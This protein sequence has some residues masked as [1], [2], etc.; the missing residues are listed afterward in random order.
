MAQIN[1]T[2][3]ITDEACTEARSAIQQGW[4]LTPDSWEVSADTSGAASPQRTYASR[5]ARWA[6][7]Q[8][9]AISA[10]GTN[11]LM[12]TITIPPNA[13]S[14]VTQV[15]EIYFI[16]K[17]Y[18]GTKFLYAIAK[19]TSPIEYRPGVS[20]AYSFVFGLNNTTVA[21]LYTIDYTYPQDISDHNA[22]QSNDI[23]TMFLKKDGTRTATGVL[24]Y[25]AAKTF[26]TARDIVDKQYVDTADSA[27]LKVDGSRQPTGILRYNSDKTFSN[28]LDIVDKKYVDTADSAL[29]KVD[30][31][32]TATGILKYN[33]AKTF[34]SDL[35]IID[36]K[37]VDDQATI[38]NVSL[39]RVSG[40]IRSV[41]NY[42]ITGDFKDEWVGTAEEYAAALSVGTITSHTMCYITDD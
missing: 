17:D 30:G 7:G 40:A 36:K 21:D 10:V 38:D 33:S 5:K 31:S 4:H 42:T 37:Y 15:A 39:K 3:Y 34:T 18:S 27:L 35:D 26:S 32:R 13:Y 19:P 20:Q 11:R 22:S 14:S 12:H 6:S 29:I 28:N 16:Y 8:F 1:F 23:H 2:T 9:S 24:K 25:D 41:G